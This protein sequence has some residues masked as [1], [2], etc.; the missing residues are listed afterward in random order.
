MSELVLIVNPQAGRGRAL[1]WIEEHGAALEREY[2]DVAT[3][4]TSEP[5]EAGLLAASVPHKT[6]IIAAVGG[7]GTINEVVNGMDRKNKILAIIPVGSGNDLIKSLEIPPEP[8]TAARLLKHGRPRAIDCGEVNGRL[9]TNSLAMGID[10]AVAEWMNKHRWLP[11]PIAYHTGVLSQLFT[12]RNRL[13]RWESSQAQ[14]EIRANMLAVMNG[15]T[16]GG[17]YRI[18]PQAKL[19]DG[20]L[21]LVIVGDY[22]VAGRIRH[23]PKVKTG[24]HL[25]LDKV[26]WLEVNELKIECD[27]MPPVALDG[28]LLDLPAGTTELNVAIHHGELKVLCPPEPPHNQQH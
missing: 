5:G 6:R 1:R 23:L 22:G 18:A 21:D 19:A 8:E 16:Y 9:F 24:A 27:D 11:S 28:E 12:F 15:H 7:D 26:S 14:G 25:E 10:G 3:I 17:G 13:F 2:G 20:W 4:L